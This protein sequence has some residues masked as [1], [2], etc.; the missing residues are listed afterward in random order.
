MSKDR[1]YPCKH[2]INE[3]NCALGKEGTFT[4]K[5]QSYKNYVKLPGSNPRRK[6]LKKEKTDKFMSNIKNFDN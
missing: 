4:K 6:N 3:G 2:Y 5:C 1:E